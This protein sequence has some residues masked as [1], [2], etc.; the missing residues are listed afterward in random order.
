MPFV[1]ATMRNNRPVEAIPPFSRAL[2]RAGSVTIWWT[3]THLTSPRD[4]TLSTLR[5]VE[6]LK[7]IEVTA[8]GEV[9]FGD[10]VS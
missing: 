6:N 8:N 5:F 1:D 7:Q 3:A 9:V 2:R 4:G 10:V